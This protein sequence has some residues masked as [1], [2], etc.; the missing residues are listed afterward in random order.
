LICASKFLFVIG[1]QS[2]VSPAA[3]VHLTLH[4]H[5]VREAH[6]HEIGV[7]GGIAFVL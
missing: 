4:I 2:F 1:G 5:V 7:L 3:G 6:Q